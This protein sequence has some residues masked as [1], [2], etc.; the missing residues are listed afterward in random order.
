MILKNKKISMLGVSSDNVL[1]RD[2]TKGIKKESFIL[3]TEWTP[4]DLIQLSN[5]IL[6]T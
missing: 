4:S 3:E 5:I 6:K 2:I 1:S